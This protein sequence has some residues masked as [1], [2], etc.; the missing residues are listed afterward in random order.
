MGKLKG[1]KIKINYLLKK[2]KTYKI[3]VEEY[4]GVDGKIIS[5]LGFE[6]KLVF[7]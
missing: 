5:K 2:Y 1:S 6:S 7:K 3:K 4:F